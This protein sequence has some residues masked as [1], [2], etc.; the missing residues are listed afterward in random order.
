MK[1]TALNCSV[2]PYYLSKKSVANADII[3]KFIN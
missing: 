2:C 3:C 1:K